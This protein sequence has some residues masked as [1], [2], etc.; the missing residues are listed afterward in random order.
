MKR[1]LMGLLLIVVVMTAAGQDGKRIFRD[2]QIRRN[3]LRAAEWQLQNPK[4]N[5]FDWTNGAF[6]AGVFAAWESTGSRGS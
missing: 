1:L 3:M 2:R 6:Y 4:H 5:L